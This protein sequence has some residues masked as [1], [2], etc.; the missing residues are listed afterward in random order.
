MI[1]FLRFAYLRRIANPNG[2]RAEEDSMKTSKN[3]LVVCA[4]LWSTNACSSSTDSPPATSD[5][6]DT[7]TAVTPMDTGESTDTGGAADTSG[8]CSPITPAGAIVH[9]DHDPGPPPAMTGGTI[10]D[11]VYA[12]TKMVQY[13]GE[14]GDTPHKDSMVFASGTG[15]I[16]GLKDGT[17]PQQTAFFSYTTAGNELSLTLTCGMSGMVKLKYTATATTITTVNDSDPNELH[18]F[19][20]M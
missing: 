5:A 17:G 16:A 14:S 4:L 19:T 9:K 7:D 3:W 13:N 6:G 8:S 1:R 11:G 20:K 2:A 12:L 18:T 10:V 15:Q